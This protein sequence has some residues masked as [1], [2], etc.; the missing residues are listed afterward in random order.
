MTPS[1]QKQTKERTKKKTHMRSLGATA[2]A[3]RK[4]RAR[5]TNQHNRERSWMKRTIALEYPCR[6]RE[7]LLLSITTYTETKQNK[8]K[9]QKIRQYGILTI[10]CPEQRW[11]DQ[12]RRTPLDKHQRIHTRQTP[13]G[14]KLVN[15]FL[16]RKKRTSLE[17][18]NPAPCEH[19][20]RGIVD[21]P[22][23]AHQIKSDERPKRSPIEASL[24]APLL[25][26]SYG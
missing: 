7:R 5:S 18:H 1:T 8:T 16:R 13:T 22:N 19:T 20:H 25:D 17:K 21:Y 12:P 4:S 11:H 14:T 9:Q 10:D 2:V 15:R 3:L 24:T 26:S 23:H 6:I